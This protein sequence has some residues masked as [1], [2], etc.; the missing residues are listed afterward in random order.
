MLQNKQNS[1]DDFTAAA[2]WLVEQGCTNH[3]KLAAHGGSNGGLLVAAA[4][5]QQPETFS[6]V[7]LDVP[8]T[9]MLRYHMFGSGSL[10]VSEYG[11]PREPE[12]FEWL[13]KYSPYHAVVG[14]RVTYPPMLVLSADSDDRVDPM[15]ARKI[16]AAVQWANRHDKTAGAFL[17]IARDSG[18]DGPDS[19]LAFAQE[20]AKTLAFLA[21]AVGLPSEAYAA[22]D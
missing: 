15:H 12:S 7:V 11:D 2:H 17:H 4:M 19:K 16:V 5:S 22:M 1:I 6:A 8:L 13:L 21:T 3:D 14:S 9:D 10:W 20:E 18:H